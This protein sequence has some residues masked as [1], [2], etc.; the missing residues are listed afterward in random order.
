MRSATGTCRYLLAATSFAC[1]AV[2]LIFLPLSSQLQARTDSQVEHM[3]SLAGN[4]LAGRFAR[5]R[6]DTERASRFYR[7]ALVRDP[8]N[9]ILLE[10]GFVVEA[11]RGNFDDAHKLAKELVDKRPTNRMAQMFLGLSAFKQKDYGAAE[12]HFKAASKGPIGELTSAI[13]IAWIR[14]AD[15]KTSAALKALSSPRQVEWAK[16]YIRYHR[17]LILDVA[18]Q[19]ERARSQFA[20]VFRQ[21]SRTLRTALAFSRHAAKNGDKRFALDI[22]RQHLEKGVGQGHPLARDLRKRIAEGEQVDLLIKTP[23]EGIAEVFYGLG[24]ALTGE[25]GVNTGILYL[26]LALYVEPEEHFALASLANA[27]ETTKDYQAAIDT[28][29]RIPRGTALQ[30][31]IDVRRAFNLNLLDRVEDARKTLLA[32]V[33]DVKAKEQASEQVSADPAPASKPERTISLPSD[34]RLLLLG[35]SGDDV[36][37]LQKILNALGYEAGPVDGIFGLGTRGALV[38]FQRDNK[39]DVDGVMGGQTLAAM[40]KPKVQDALRGAGL[41]SGD[42]V[43]GLASLKADEAAARRGQL[44]E[45]YDALGNIMRS[46]KRYSEA[47]DYYT[48]AIDLVVRPK[49]RHWA[50]YYSRGTCYE[51]L[52]RWPPA[53]VDL[54]KALELQPNQPLALNYLGY[55][56]IDQNKNLKKGLKLIEKAVAAKPEDGYIVDSLGWAHYKLGNYKKAV[57][58]LER[59]VELRPEDPVLNDHLGDA[60]WQDSRRREARF[61]WEQALTLNPEPEDERKIKKKLEEGLQPEKRAGASANDVPLPEQ[62]AAGPAQ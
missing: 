8:G 58:Y 45:I 40:S 32:I 35:D 16:F 48:N 13:A 1:L 2:L 19:S 49:D 25:G 47:I 43:A 52:K 29:E 30:A 50:L 6:N 31:A 44:I 56:W 21:D 28:Y 20:N 41:D 15:G 54:L 9:A 5:S 37:R 62:R 39:I 22:L 18:G 10:N 57:R 53:E 60:L 59:A 46:R 12:A 38:A 36:A 26:Q 14:L 23:S 61:Q 55:S 27:Y 34:E 3:R 24:E 42:G 4:Y 11:M 7:D 51:R 33:D 17:A